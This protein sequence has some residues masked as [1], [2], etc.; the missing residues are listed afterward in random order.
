MGQEYFINSQQ[1]ES[2]VRKLLPSQGGIGAG[3]DLSASTQII[4]IV[5]LTESAEGSSLRQD[6]QRAI[7]F[8]NVTSFNFQNTS[9]T[10]L[11]LLVIGKSKALLLD[12]Q[13]LAVV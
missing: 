8:S 4:P 3:I 1:L 5:D 10:I 12:N 7:S 9:G 2:Q 13:M 6:L 11:I